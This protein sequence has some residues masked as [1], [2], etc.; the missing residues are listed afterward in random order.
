MPSP[1]PDVELGPGVVLKG[2][3]QIGEGA[4]SAPT[5]N[6]KTASWRPGLPFFLSAAWP[7]ASIGESTQVG[8]FTRLRQGAVLEEQSKVGNFVEVKKTELGP[9]SKAN[10]LAYLGDATIGK[11]PAL[12]REPSP[13]TTTATTSIRQ[14]SVQGLSLAQTAPLL[15]PSRLAMAPL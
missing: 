14:T 4:K 12:E 2:R 8:P 10:H 9:G 1:L 5:A 15:L 3:T 13:A 11:M 7:G 6:S